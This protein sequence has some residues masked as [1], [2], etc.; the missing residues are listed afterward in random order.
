MAKV[1]VPKE[2]RPPSRT[3][4]FD[5]CS[6]HEIC[7]GRFRVKGLFRSPKMGEF[8]WVSKETAGMAGNGNG[9]ASIAVFDFKGCPRVIL[10]R[11]AA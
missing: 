11:V 1:R 7:K 4:V 8:F 2:L 6:P 9:Y 5:G 3:N 10:E